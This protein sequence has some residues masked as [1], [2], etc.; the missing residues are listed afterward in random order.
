M[1]ALGFVAVGVGA[2]LGAWLR[3][4]LGLLFGALSS[5]VHPGTL[6]ANLIGGYL[7]GVAVCWHERGKLYAY[8][9]SPRPDDTAAGTDRARQA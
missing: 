5:P 1:N 3:W 7:V 8:R 6:A 2:A 9:Q 4:A